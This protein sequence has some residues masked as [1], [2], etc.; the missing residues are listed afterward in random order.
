MIDIF[1][2]SKDKESTKQVPSLE[3]AS[4]PLPE[5][6]YDAK[7]DYSI[8][9]KA[10]PR[11][12]LESRYYQP[13]KLIRPEISN[14]HAINQQESSRVECHSAFKPLAKPRNQLHEDH[15]PQIKPRSVPKDENSITS[16][17]SNIKSELEA[18][19]STSSSSNLSTSSSNRSSSSSSVSA[20]SLNQPSQGIVS[21][22]R[23]I[24]E[25]PEKT[26]NIELITNKKKLFNNYE[27][28]LVS[29]KKQPLYENLNFMQSDRLT[30]LGVPPCEAPPP[31]LPLSLPPEDDEPD[32][33]QRLLSDTS[34]STNY[35]LKSDFRIL[36]TDRSNTPCSKSMYASQ[37][38]LIKD[39]PD[40]VDEVR[41][42][43]EGQRHVIVPGYMTS[44]DILRNILLKNNSSLPVNLKKSEPSETLKQK[45]I[46]LNEKDEECL[47]KKFN[48]NSK[49]KV[50]SGEIKLEKEEV[51]D[52]D[53]DFRPAKPPRT[54]E[55]DANFSSDEKMN[56]V[57][58]VSSRS[59]LRKPKCITGSFDP[60]DFDS[61]DEDEF[62]SVQPENFICIEPLDKIMGDALDKQK[63]ELDL[64]KQ[65]E[66][67]VQFDAD[68]FDSF[69]EE[70]LDEEVKFE[71]VK[72]NQVI[73]THYR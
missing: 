57:R 44:A 18:F 58:T 71:S 65:K 32:Q 1:I 30:E 35:T 17:E 28:A 23:N 60:N 70:Y 63:I 33:K 47:R 27:S 66:N 11:K 36:S 68:D 31:P 20:P 43:Y 2:D 62:E 21:Q 7:I 10:T 69:D 24:F 73:E 49:P 64:Q 61:F 39:I 29:I 51:I 38:L 46:K 15:V 55:T 26:K 41:L 50:I 19:C 54:F 40:S 14:N 45:L 8:H 5:L 3:F 12:S 9:L 42:E 22:M 52:I 56:S 53:F 37:N 13:R 67:L 4:C 16:T 6:D 72:S 34:S 25:S 59:S 48:Q